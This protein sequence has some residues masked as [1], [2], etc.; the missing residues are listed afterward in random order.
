MRNILP[1]TGL[2]AAALLLLLCCPALAQTTKYQ[3][4][5]AELS[6]LYRGKLPN[7]YP[8]KY[9][10]TY[11]LET[12]TFSTGSILY[13]GKQYN[14]VILNLDAVSQDLVVR[15]SEGA[16]G[17][18][19]D[20][21]QV[22]WFTL[23]GR[24]FVNLE[25]MG[26][27]EAP[28]GYLELVKDG[29][30]PVF[31]FRRKVFRTETNPRN[32]PEM[33]GNYNS[34]VANTFVPA[35]EYYSIE[36]GAVKK[37]KK[38]AYN[39]RMR[40]GSDAGPSPL[41][42]KMNRWHPTAGSYTGGYLPFP[43]SL[44]QGNALP[45]GFFSERKVDTTTVLYASNALTATYRNKLYIIGETGATK[46][47]KA[48]ISGTV[49]EAESGEPLPGVVVY[50]Q[51]TGTYARTGANGQYKISLPMGDNLLNFN[52][53]SKEDL[54][55]KIDLRS[56]GALDV[57]MTEKITLLK[58]SIISAESMRQHRNT[59]MGVEA[60]SMKTIN[61]I[62]SA[63]GE[64]DIIKAV[65]TLPGVKSVGEASGGF[66]VRGGSSDQNLILYNDNT[67]YNPNHLFG[68]FSAFNP[69]LIDNVELY[70]SSI[71]A[72]YGGRISSVL[73]VKSKEGDS[74]R[75]R[76]SLG[77]GVLTSRAHIEGPIGKLTF[78]AG[79]R[80]AYSDW[81]LKLLPK[82]SAY[83]GGGAGFG[84]ANLG[85]TYH[86]DS[87]NSL[88]LFGY[89][90]TDR[91]SFSGD[92]TFRYTN[93]NGALTFRHKGDDGSSFKFSAGYD[94]YGNIT[95]V[96]SWESGAYDLQTLIRQAFVKINRSRP[97]GHHKLGYGLDVV[98]YLLDPGT[99]TPFGTNSQVTQRKLNPE[100]GVEP[101]AYISDLWAPT[102]FFS[103]EGGIRLSTFLA[104][105]PN[106]FYLGPE[107]RI[108]TKLSPA[109]NVSFKAGF[110][111][112]RQYTHLISNTASVSP[113]DTWRLSSESIAPTTGWQAAAGFY[114]TLLGA[115]LDFSLEGYYKQSKNN[116]D[117]KTGA[118]LSMNPNLADDLVPVQG[119]AY[120]VEVMLKKPA[121]K[122]TGW[123]S[124]SYSRSM[125]QEMTD[126]GAATINGG[127][128][129]NAPYDKPH[130][131][132]MVVNWAFTHRF[133][134]SMNLD[135]STGR[136]ITVPL[137][138]Y[139]YGGSYRLA[140]GD[141]N[142]YRIPDYFR[143]DAAVNIDPG[144]YLK[145]FAH[146]SI[147]IGVYN[148]TGRKNPYSVFF[149][150]DNQGVVQG[151]MMSVFAT[152]IPYINLNILF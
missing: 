82:N 86:F 148:I 34:D 120:G 64:G 17:V 90:A 39:K 58:G 6:T 55:L 88:Q 151:Y 130:E 98:G 78:I 127:D 117:Y 42:E 35:E 16:G 145:A 150:T 73:S 104:M 122:L 31:K 9:N 142:T 140:Y 15:P 5:A 60:V 146:A 138:R 20:R 87:H 89:Y 57:V 72:E 134:I 103:I 43:S 132:K 24:R 109:K 37:L 96:N 100:I 112:M 149:R 107:Y 14:D 40:E 119:K 29:K 123:V 135:Y 106:K 48:V 45:E 108:S 143:I 19:L 93:I 147:T 22:A 144:H 68:V 25:Y 38:S 102:D 113:M 56:S 91:F 70:K 36:N 74:K 101:A 80:I 53:E 11:F 66:N 105:N 110:N 115:G 32:T 84:D 23:G 65:L 52:A 95:N 27:K 81:M 133:S 99:L 139:Y 44:G 116:L 71:P 67:I 62:P 131:V 51:N 50:D 2:T 125:L 85:L 97:L 49:F 92:T 128:W 114:W 8:Y 152:Q 137:G 59:A 118:V 13:N 79:G 111:T 18:I 7:P 83:A 61:K 41:E 77:I 28:K 3:K 4:D 12:R 126:R 121:G 30:S 136:P 10:G 63:F 33:D 26:Y 129:Y 21:N 46:G 94:H 124:Y 47:T 141:R 54:A 69:D 76:G 75:V 1:K